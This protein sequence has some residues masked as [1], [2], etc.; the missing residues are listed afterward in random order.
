[1]SWNRSYSNVVHLVAGSLCARLAWHLMFL[2]LGSSLRQYD[3][4]AARVA[5]VP[6]APGTGK[7]QHKGADLH[8]YG[9]MRVRSLL[10][11]EQ[12]KRTLA[13][14]NES[15]HKIVLQFTSLASLS[16]NPVREGAE[17]LRLRLDVHSGAS[18]STMTV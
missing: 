12:K 16:N 3:F 18:A 11:Q 8:K 7:K 13:N 10:S 4:R 9:H 15:G 17:L 2:L 1:M 6:S 5:L 14:Q